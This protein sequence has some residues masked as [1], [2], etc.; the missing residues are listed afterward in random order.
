MDGVFHQNLMVGT[1]A[2]HLLAAA[3]AGTQ[4]RRH[5]DQRNLHVNAS[6]FRMVM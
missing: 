6:C 1:D 5:D 4:A 2:V 3:V